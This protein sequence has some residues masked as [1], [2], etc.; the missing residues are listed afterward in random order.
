MNT[1]KKKLFLPLPKHFRQKLP[2]D[3]DVYLS[4][5]NKKL[6]LNVLKN[7]FFAPQI[8]IKVA[9]FRLHSNE[10]KLYVD[11]HQQIKVRVRIA[12]QR[13]IFSASGEMLSIR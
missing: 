8:S 4:C 11:L 13:A 10:A 1:H 5:K 12:Q 9:D 2:Y 6:S 7:Y 3:F